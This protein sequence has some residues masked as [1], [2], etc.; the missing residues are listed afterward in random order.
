MSLT[1]AKSILFTFSATAIYTTWYLF[2]NNGSSDLMIHVRD[3]GPRVLPGTNEPLKTSYTGIQWID[4]ELTVLTLCFWE[5]VDGSLPSASLLC[6]HFVGQI[7]A[8]WGLFM[9]E[10]LR[11]GNRGRWISLYVRIMLAFKL[12][13][14]T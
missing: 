1:V 12:V 7:A 8:G 2:M 6:F 3:V 13:D 5:M 4:Y 11:S 14:C 10:A 9:L